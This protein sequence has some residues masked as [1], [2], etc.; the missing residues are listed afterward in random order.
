MCRPVYYGIRLCNRSRQCVQIIAAVTRAEL[1]DRFSNEFWRSVVRLCASPDLKSVRG[2]GT[3]LLF[4]LS[5]E[6]FLVTATHVLKDFEGQQ[7]MAFIDDREAA[8]S[9]GGQVIEVGDLPD[10]AVLHLDQVSLKRLNPNHFRS[11]LDLDSTP[12]AREDQ[13]FIGGYPIDP[14]FCN[15]SLTAWK[16]IPILCAV[17][18]DSSGDHRDV[19]QLD[20]N[21]VEDVHGERARLPASLAG[22]S[23]GPVFRLTAMGHVSIV[24]V[25]TSESR[26]SN[27]HKV[28]ATRWSYV[29]GL[30]DNEL[31]GIRGAT[32]LLLPPKRL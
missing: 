4:R 16:A 32:R 6:P 9:L 31:G 12:L 7:I 10:V 18:L 13:Y 20:L 22:M 2:G 14:N 19:F 5:G 17:Q 30:I 26:E 27:I 28:H 29:L 23:G 3:G 15:A 11:Q 1:L 25:V 8:V 21:K 24:G